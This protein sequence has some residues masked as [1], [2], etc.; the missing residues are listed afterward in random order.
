MNKREFLVGAVALATVD[1]PALAAEH[2]SS[3]AQPGVSRRLP[4]LDEQHSLARWQRYVGES[5][6]LDV[7]GAPSQTL[8]LRRI[9]VDSRMQS[10]V[11][12]FSVL[13]EAAAPI[14]TATQL[15]TLRHASGQRLALNLDA[16]R[17]DA[18]PHGYRAHFSLMT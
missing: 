4:P 3:L 12:Q 9:D 8:L 1:L 18:G 15:C 13:F 7:P 5:F 11:E 16:V 6:T 2:S 14:Q 17:T 10:Q